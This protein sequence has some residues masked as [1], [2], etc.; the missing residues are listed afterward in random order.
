VGLKSISKE[1]RS[2]I[3]PAEQTLLLLNGRLTAVGPGNDVVRGA[4]SGWLI[5]GGKEHPRSRA[6]RTRRMLSGTVRWARPTSR[7]SPAPAS[8]MGITLPSH[9]IRRA[10]AALISCP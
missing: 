9:A 7:G 10:V 4:Q 1:A 3:W 5:T 2:G 8:T 6:T